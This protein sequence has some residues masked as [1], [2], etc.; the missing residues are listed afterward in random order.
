MAEL[1]IMIEHRDTGKYYFPMVEEGVKWQTDREGV[2]GKA[3][4]KII[5]DG[6][7]KVTEGDA[8]R[9]TYGKAKVFF[10]FVFERN[11][12]TSG[13]IDITAYDQLRYLTNKDTYQYKNKTASQV[14]KMLAS[15]FSLKIGK[16]SIADTKY[17]IKK[18]T[19]QNMSLFDIIGNALD[20]TMLNTDQMY[21]LYSDFDKLTLKN[22]ADMYVKDGNGYFVVTGETLTD[23]TYKTSIDKDVYNQIKLEK[24]DKDTGRVVFYPAYDTKN[25]NKWGVLQYFEKLQD[26]E[27]GANKAKALLKLY[28]EKTH[29]LELKNVK[30]NVKVR[31]GSLICVSMKVGDIKINNP[32]LVEKAVHTWESSNYRMDLIVRGGMINGA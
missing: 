13:E 31:A 26:G 12:D 18:R 3:T 8:V 17:V 15:D 25:I 20:I 27:N 14:I 30:G 4:F 23:Y 7:V 24:D 22:L 1:E 10:G 9:I 21:V 16:N 6:K 2:P 28:N 11:F 19:E 29:T 32:M 5:N